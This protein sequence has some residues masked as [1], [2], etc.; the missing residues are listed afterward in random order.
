MY[1]A[2]LAFSSLPSF[3][4]YKKISK[5]T[6]RGKTYRSVFI[7]L[8]LG[9]LPKYTSKVISA[10][11]CLPFPR[12]AIFTKFHE[13]SS[14]LDEREGFVSRYVPAFLSYIGF[15]QKYYNYIN[16]NSL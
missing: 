4:K 9:D 16:A 8:S 6:I 13:I 5:E 10:C 12:I 11:A 2:S 7:Y 15:L 3:I 14:V 1:C